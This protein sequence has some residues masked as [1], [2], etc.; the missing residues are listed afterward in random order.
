MQSKEQASSA[1]VRSSSEGAEEH[2]EG[3]GGGGEGRQSLINTAYQTAS[4][5]AHVGVIEGNSK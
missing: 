2:G 3:M 4:V 5:Y 1:D